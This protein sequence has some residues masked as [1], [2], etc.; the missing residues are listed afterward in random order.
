MFPSFPLKLGAPTPASAF[1]FVQTDRMH[2]GGRGAAAG[3]RGA[4][5]CSGS[6][7][8][9]G[10]GPQASGH[11]AGKPPPCACVLLP[12][13]LAFAFRF[14]LN[15]APSR[16]PV[17][18]QKARGAALPSWRV[19]PAA[20][21]LSWFGNFPTSRHPPRPRAPRS[22]GRPA[23]LKAQDFRSLCEG[24]GTTSVTVLTT[25]L[26]RRGGRAGR[27]LERSNSPPRNINILKYFPSLLLTLF[28]SQCV[29][30]YLRFYIFLQHWDN[31]VFY[32]EF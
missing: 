5:M 3:R 9:C 8:G 32:P 4:S 23:P 26:R 27:G 31:T 22:R 29:S 17:I 30:V 14:P 13:S 11:L 12:R 20:R 19:P 6:S 16:S 18:S 24:A 1:H 2:Q 21:R 15:P 10:R 28:L 25:D 7:G